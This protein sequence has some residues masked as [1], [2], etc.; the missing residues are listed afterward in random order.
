MHAASEEVITIAILVSFDISSV[1][2]IYATHQPNHL[3]PFSMGSTAAAKKSDRS[4]APAYVNSAINAEKENIFEAS[5][6]VGGS[7]AEPVK[8]DYSLPSKT[9]T[10]LFLRSFEDDSNTSLFGFSPRASPT[11]APGDQKSLAFW[12]NPNAGQGQFYPNPLHHQQLLSPP[13][14]TAGVLENWPYSQF[15]Q[16][17]P[18]GL[19]SIRP[20]NVPEQTFVQYGQFTPP[21]DRASEDFDYDI[22]SLQPKEQHDRLPEPPQSGKRKRTSASAKEPSKPPKRARKSAGRPKFSTQALTSRNSEDDKR[23]KFL[24][25][26]RVAASKCRQ[27]KKEWTSSLETRARELQHSKNQMAMMVSSLKEEVMFLKGEMLKHTSC[28]CERIRDYLNREVNSI[29]HNAMHASQP[30]HSAASVVGSEPGGYTDDVGGD[31]SPDNS[32]RDSNGSS[33]RASERES[34]SPMGG[35]KTEMEFESMLASSLVH[36]ISN[37]EIAGR[38]GK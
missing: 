38:A 32:R 23:S 10:N 29:A 25:R 11:I 33:S 22:S 30:F 7:T 21:N 5:F 14:S 4:N 2:T 20:Q 19:P 12:R 13:M 17:P 31:S 1:N 8:P 34:L 15:S 18:I 35:F 37:E 16:R 28:G 36:N 26:N 9:D 24:E 3:P 27:K 6:Q